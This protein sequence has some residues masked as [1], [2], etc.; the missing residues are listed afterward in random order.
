[1]SRCSRFSVARVFFFLFRK[2]NESDSLHPLKQ[3][4]EIEQKINDRM[5]FNEIKWNQKRKE[6]KKS[7]VSS[8][9]SGRGIQQLSPVV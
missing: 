4:G 5:V 9:S 3:H 2:K 7:V 6:R 1:M 8:H